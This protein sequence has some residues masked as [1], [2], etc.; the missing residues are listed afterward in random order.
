ME[1]LEFIMGLFENYPILIAFL[2]GLFG[3]EEV[4]ITLSF[5][6]A[7]GFIPIWILFVFALIGVFLSDIFV[8]FIGKLRIIK[9]FKNI[10]KFSKV[11]MQ[12][13]SRISKLTR[14][15]VFL[16]L[17]YTKFLYGTRVLT[18]IYVGLK[19]IKL[20]KFMLYDFIVTFIWMCVIVSIGWF[21]G[22][23]YNLIY[24]IFKNVQ[25]ALLT[26]LIFVVLFFILRK[27]VGKKLIK[28]RKV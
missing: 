11:Y 21:A 6:S 8:F 9:N 20:R 19:D 26:I 3:G 22:S 12:V 5:L 18:L 27:W 4:I 25:I 13:D 23:S 14:E 7:N 28:M 10:E 24:K 2:G 1:I 16:T 17:L 15:S